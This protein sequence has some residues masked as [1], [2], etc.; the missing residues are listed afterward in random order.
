MV[1]SLVKDSEIPATKTKY[2][3]LSKLVQH[4]KN[5]Q[6]RIRNQI[7]AKVE[8]AV[9]KIM[10]EYLDRKPFNATLAEDL[11]KFPRADAIKQFQ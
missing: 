10:Q 7:N 2:G 1:M 3:N 8:V 6:L 11:A 5:R 4:H 9:G